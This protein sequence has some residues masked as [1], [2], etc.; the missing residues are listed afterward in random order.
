MKPNTGLPLK[1]PTEPDPKTWLKAERSALLISQTASARTLLQKAG[2]WRATLCYWV[3]E[4]ASLEAN[5]ESQDEQQQLNELEKKWKEKKSFE[6]LYLTQDTL[7]AKLRVTPATKIW[8]REHWADNVDSLF[9]NSKSYLTRAS[10]RIIRIKNK[11]LASELYHRIKAKET[12]FDE[13]ARNFG[14]G[15]ERNQGGFIPLQPLGSIPFG[16]APVLEHLKQGE[17]MQPIRLGKVFCIVELVEY[18]NSQLDEATEEMLLAEQ[19][20]LWID[21]VVDYIEANLV[22]PGS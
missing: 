2:L 14:E 22:W 1:T 19:F 7:R 11:S 13:A 8:C 3:R 15:P 20:R 4:Q 12:S 18:H 9:L 6:G 16:L 10:C 5:W 21:T 17:I